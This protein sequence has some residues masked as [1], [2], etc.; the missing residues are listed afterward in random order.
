[1][2]DNNHCYVHDENLFENKIYHLVVI[3]NAS[4]NANKNEIWNDS[5][6][7]VMKDN[8]FA[9]L[10]EN[11]S[12][13]LIVIETMSVNRNETVSDDERSEWYVSNEAMMWWMNYCQ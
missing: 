12:V 7:D 11:E 9:G 1:M 5:N 4:E 6:D 3:A 2:S 10:N 13:I 8:D